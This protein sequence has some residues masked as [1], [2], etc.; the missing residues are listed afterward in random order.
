[1]TDCHPSQSFPTVS[2]GLGGASPTEL[3][4]GP[5]D[6]FGPAPHGDGCNGEGFQARPQ[7]AVSWSHSPSLG[8]VR[9]E[10][11]SPWRAANIFDLGPSRGDAAPARCEAARQGVQLVRRQFARSRL[12]DRLRLA[13]RPQFSVGQLGISSKHN[14]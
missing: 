10:A 4:H 12:P 6:R 2:L 8:D 9:L 14:L 1:M 11:E 5:T 3:R 7:R 13:R